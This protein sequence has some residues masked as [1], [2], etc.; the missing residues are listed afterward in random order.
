MY[1]N[2]FGVNLTFL[3]HLHD[4][5]EDF[6]TAMHGAQRMNLKDFQELLTFPQVHVLFIMFPAA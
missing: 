1:P 6:A 3:S 2:D 5:L 4:G